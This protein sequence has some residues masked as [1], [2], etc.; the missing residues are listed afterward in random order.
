MVSLK[1]PIVSSHGQV[2]HH[3]LQ[4]I[5]RQLWDG[6]ALQHRQI[7]RGDHLKSMAIRWWFYV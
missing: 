1:I 3:L 7:V 4:G 6:Q 5:L 2:S